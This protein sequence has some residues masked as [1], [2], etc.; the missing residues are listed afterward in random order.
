MEVE[1]MVAVA[2]RALPRCVEVAVEVAATFAVARAGSDCERE[3][4]RTIGWAGG[5]D[6]AS[7]VGGFEGGVGE[8]FGV[9]AG[10]VEQMMVPG[11][12]Q[13][14]VVDPG[15]AAVVPEAHVV[16]LAPVGGPVAAGETA[17]PVPDHQGVEQGG[18]DGAGGAAVVEDGGPPGGHHPVQ[19]G[20]AQQPL[21]AGP[22]EPGA[23]GGGGT[24]GG[25]G[26]VTLEVDDQVEMGAVAAT[27]AVLLVVQEVAADVAQ[28]V[29]P[30]GGRGAGGLAVVVGAGGEAQGGGQQLT[31][32][33]AQG[34]VGAPA[35]IEGAGQVQRLGPFGLGVGVGGG[36]LPPAA[37]G[38]GDVAGG[39][40]DQGRHDGGLVGGEQVEGGGVEVGGDGFDLPARQHPV[41]P[42]PGG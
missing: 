3:W 28:G 20:I 14:Q 23:V 7:G 39:E 11:T 5:A 34:A 27:A 17:V 25:V 9:P 6:S 12:E 13:H 31:G 8:E 19:G 2:G 30:A 26:E 36:G 41:P 29:G 37:H 15:G 24:G 21:D 18:G 16:A 4:G 22:I 40:V 10:A 38:D 42:R 35:V 33:G 32:L 1:A